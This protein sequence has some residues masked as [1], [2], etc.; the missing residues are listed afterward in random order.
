[1]EK[2]K[3]LFILLSNGCFFASSLVSMF[4][5]LAPLDWH[6]WASL[7]SSFIFFILLSLVLLYNFKILFS[8]EIKG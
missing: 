3:V 6:F 7:A 8:E 5:H 1:M 2:K 4:I